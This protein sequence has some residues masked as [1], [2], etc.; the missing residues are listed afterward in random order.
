[1]PPLTILL[2]LQMSHGAGST[3]NSSRWQGSGAHQLHEVPVQHKMGTC[4]HGKRIDLKGP[5]LVVAH[6]EALERVGGRHGRAEHCA[7]RV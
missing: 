1:M 4:A 2:R 7:G 3:L 6:L 5:R